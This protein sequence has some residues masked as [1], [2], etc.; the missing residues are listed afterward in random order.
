[1][2]REVCT[3]DATT[4]VEAA[5][6]EDVA[7]IIEVL[8]AAFAPFAEQLAPTALRQTPD[9][10]AGELDRWLIAR[11]DG[12]LVGCVMHY[13]EDG[14]YTLCLGYRKGTDEALARRGLESFHVVRKVKSG[15]VG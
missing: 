12:Q 4:S 5:R 8:S 13:A 10:V 11:R 15:L 14:Y 1:M 3:D 9:T 6:A 2:G 7:E